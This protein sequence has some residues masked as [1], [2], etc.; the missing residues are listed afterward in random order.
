MSIKRVLS[1][2]FILLILLLGFTTIKP[3]LANS[4]Y[5]IFNHN[6]SLGSINNDVKQL[7]IYLN[8]N[9]FIVAKTG[10]GSK[11]KET[12]KFGSA[13]KASL[14]KFQKVNKIKPSVG[15][16]GPIT[17]DFINKKIKKQNTIINNT[18]N[19]NQS[20]NNNNQT[21]NN[22][23]NNNSN[24]NQTNNTNNNTS[25]TSNN[26]HFGGGGLPSYTITYLAGDHGA[27]TGTTP[28]NV[29]YG[30][31]GVAITATPNT[32]YYFVDWSDGVLTPERTDTNITS[33]LSLT[34]TF[35]INSYTL[36]YTAGTHG[37]ITGT[38][39]QTINYGSDAT[40]VTATPDEGCYFVNW[41]DG[42]LTP[43]RTDLNITSNKSVTANFN[44]NS[45][46]LTYTAGSHGT[47]S[48]TTP[49][50]IDYNTNG[51]A[52]TATPDTG[53]YFVSWSD[54]VL[55]A[56]RTDT[57]IIANKSVTANFQINSYTL[58]YTAGT[59]GTI[60]GT[61][62]Q[63]INYGS[64]GTA[65]TAVPD[66]G[67]Y[68]V[69]W[70]DSSTANPRTDTSVAGNISVTATFAINPFVTCGDNVYYGG[71]FYPTVSIGN[72]CW[73][74]KNLDIGTMIGSK[75]SDNT[76]A[77]NQANN[78]LVEKYCYGYVQQ[79]NVGQITTG[80]T[81]CST[82][83][84]LYQWT[85]ALGLPYDCNSVTPT[86][87]S[88]ST[89]TLTCPTSGSQTIQ[90]QQQG[91][92]PIGWHIPNRYEYI[93]LIGADLSGGC[94]GGGI[95]GGKL[96][97]TASHTP[98]SWN[99]TDDYGFSALPSGGLDTIFRNRGS[100]TVFWSQIPYLS[101]SMAFS[102]SNDISVYK[103]PYARSYGY[104]VRCVKNYS[105]YILSYAN[106]SNGSLTGT[107]LQVIN[108]GSSSTAVTAIPN[109]GYHFVNW[110]DSSTQNPRTDTNVTDNLSV[111]ASFA[112]NS[113]TLTY[114]AGAHG[115]ITGTT[116]QTVN[117]NG[118]GTAVTAVADT[119][120]HFVNW[121]DN[122]TANPRTDT[123]V[124]SSKSVTAN[125]IINPSFVCGNNVS[126]GGEL[127]PTT[128]IG[129]QCWMAK[130]LDIGT[131]VD[132]GNPN[133]QDISG[134]DSGLW[135]CQT[136]DSIIEKYCYNNDPANCA[137]DS[138]LYEWAE[139]LQLPYD[140]NNAASID[141]GNGTYTLDCS[142]SGAQTISAVQQG[143][144][145]T[146]WHI[147]NYD[148]WQTLA[149][150]SDPGCDLN[151]DYGDCSCS[152]AGLLLKSQP[153]TWD[154]T[155]H[156][157][158]DF[159]ALPSGVYYNNA[160][161]YYRGVETDFWSST[162]DPEN[163]SLSWD[164]YLRTDYSELMGFRSTRVSAYSVRCIKN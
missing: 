108:P 43:E 42:V 27:I 141:N 162:I 128:Q 70:S 50:T 21:N 87:N 41:S 164:V 161:F 148:D 152:S 35:A 143:I 154:G 52:V 126:Y 63:T 47:I 131:R 51:T 60:S 4:S 82:D 88:N 31:D 9:G 125:F 119:G 86:I 95:V 5:F 2:G 157:I 92:C 109:T 110:S 135:S 103:C 23:N 11:G 44:I 151:C 40:T 134:D 10:P 84:G 56:T 53:Y 147:P 36:T 145:P 124:T 91:I 114:T 7:Q 73:L 160:T 39:P 64:N 159:E 33:N 59:H 132:S 100:A 13:T 46:T 129:D 81:N 25:N 20:N 153:P 127:Y 54:D 106:S 1:L 80:T 71:E 19:N 79:D 99:G 24:N 121:S 102:L 45:Y 48:G 136:N 146:G 29:N 65:V 96:K 123:Y 98:I 26:F 18:N 34:A 113:Y 68:F 38:T 117:Y 67:Y 83:G 55:T 37:T 72:Q 89:Y 12:T 139:A 116:P 76:T 150:V 74:A 28:Q 49:Q 3:I 85:E 158:Y 58:T 78:S 75:L 107:L 93:N 22:N 142:I 77:Q 155:D 97:A 138:G 149:Q 133:C 163:S 16:F 14:I 104:S 61:T 90:Y 105:S 17:R 137:T 30:G 57:N 66:T 111:T 94:G 156:D 8:N 32:G 112:I 140:C 69:S 15:Y 120:Y 6:L 122:S 130:N 118:S 115:S 101:Q 62:P 144:C